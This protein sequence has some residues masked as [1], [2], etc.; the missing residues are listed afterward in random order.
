MEVSPELSDFHAEFAC[1]PRS[2]P[3]TTWIPSSAAVSSQCA[4]R[5]S[6][7][8][9]GMAGTAE[10]DAYPPEFESP[11]SLALVP[12]L[13]VYDNARAPDSPCL[14]LSPPPGFGH[15]LVTSDASSKLV[16]EDPFAWL[17]SAAEIYARVKCGAVAMKRTRCAGALERTDSSVGETLVEVRPTSLDGIPSVHPL[18]LVK[19]CLLLE[20]SV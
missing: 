19:S 12:Q 4:A 20:V 11:E 17:G 10:R 13:R 15:P 18:S 1:L 5:G 9:D 2:H 6:N 7:V 14:Q 8:S 3:L 16:P